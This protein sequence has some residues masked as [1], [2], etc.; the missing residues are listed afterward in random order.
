[1][2][3]KSAYLHSEFQEKVCLEQPERFEKGNNLE[4]KLRKSIYGLRQAA[5]NWY[6]KFMIFRWK[7]K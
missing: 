5:R 7:K 1:M 6:K 2:D 4:C 3:V